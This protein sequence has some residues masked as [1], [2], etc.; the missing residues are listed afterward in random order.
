MAITKRILIRIPV[1]KRI[2]LLHFIIADLEKQVEMYNSTIKGNNFDFVVVTVDEED[3]I[4]K[5]KNA[6]TYHVYQPNTNLGEKL[7]KSMREII[8]DFEFDYLL[9]LGSD[10]TIFFKA[11]AEYN[12]Q[13]L[14][15]H[16]VFGFN[17]LF[18]RKIDSV[19]PLNITDQMVVKYPQV[20]G[21]GRMISREAIEKVYAG[22]YNLWDHHIHEGNDM[23][24]QKNLEKAGYKTHCIDGLYITDYKSDMNIQS[25]EKLK[26]WVV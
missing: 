24:A 13:I 14:K 4:I 10:D 5:M 21:A 19:N 23:N 11:F 26:K 1:Y 12:H 20:I 15:G 16:H 3:P 22:G 2:E 25:Y 6:P 17:H 9:E 18:V 7:D 8:N